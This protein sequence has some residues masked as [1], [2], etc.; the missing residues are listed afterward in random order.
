MWC[1][2]RGCVYVHTEIATL[3]LTICPYVNKK[4]IFISSTLKQSEQNMSE[5]NMF[6]VKSASVHC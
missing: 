4:R 1:L 6:T 3:Q 2:K 5:Q